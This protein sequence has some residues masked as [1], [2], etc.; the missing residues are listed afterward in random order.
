MQEKE[1][2]QLLA[3]KNGSRHN[4]RH[5]LA[6]WR[7]LERMLRHHPHHFNGLLA[8]CRHQEPTAAGQPELLP[9][10][11]ITYLKT[12]GV[13]GKDSEVRPIV[14]DVLLSSYQITPDGPAMTLPFAFSSHEERL[15]FERIANQT[16]QPFKT[17][18]RN[19]LSGRNDDE[20][21]SR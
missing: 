8:L 13:L 4:A 18:L 6:E 21:L 14:R 10:D 1:E 15:I 5:A 19:A 7:N 12:D 17:W 20:E 16:N 11:S 9:A 3:L 2:E